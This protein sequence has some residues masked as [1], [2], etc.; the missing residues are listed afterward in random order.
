MLWFPQICAA[1]VA[2]GEPH[3]VPDSHVPVDNI[4]LILTSNSKTSAPFHS[5]FLIFS[6]HFNIIN[7]IKKHHCGITLHL[8]MINLL[9]AFQKKFKFQYN[10]SIFHQ[11][12]CKSLFHP[13]SLSSTSPSISLSLS[14]KSW[15]ML[16]VSVIVIVINNGIINVIEIIIFWPNLKLYF[17]FFLHISMWMWWTLFFLQLIFIKHKIR[18]FIW[19]RAHMSYFILHYRK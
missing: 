1:R 17:F 18:V 3:Q 8:S 10:L 15:T 13:Q 9:I 4:Y 14:V 7:N 2:S 19:G 6:S 16:N 5:K 12:L 11:S